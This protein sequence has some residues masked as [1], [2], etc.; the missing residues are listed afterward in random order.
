MHDEQLMEQQGTIIQ[1]ASALAENV[2]EPMTPAKLTA[3]IDA[4]K[5]LLALMVLLQP[6]LT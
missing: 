4:T 2:L 1:S 6:A 3:W 5:S